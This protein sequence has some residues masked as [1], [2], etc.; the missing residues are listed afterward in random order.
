MY[1]K[2]IISQH[3]RDFDAVYA[4]EHCKHEFKSG[5][6]DDDNFHR[7]VV[8]KKECPKCNKK[9]NL[10]TYRPFGTKYREDEV[11]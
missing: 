7:N 2:R 8:P 10:D 11:V 1:I 6:Y 5:G 4:C 9:A 3:R